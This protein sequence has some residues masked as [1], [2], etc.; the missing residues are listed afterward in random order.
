MANL[1]LID[2]GIRDVVDGNEAA[3]RAA[4][5]L[6]EVVAIYPITPASPMGELA[7]DWSELMEAL[8]VTRRQSN[9]RGVT[10]SVKLNHS[11]SDNSA[12]GDDRSL[13]HSASRTNAAPTPSRT[14]NRSRT[15]SQEKNTPNSGV[16]NIDTATR[17]GG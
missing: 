6:S 8:D 10:S 15:I 1:S 2:P 17:L 5:L 12:G 14:C 11:D 3:A 4:H 16:R 9:C 13:I 7:D